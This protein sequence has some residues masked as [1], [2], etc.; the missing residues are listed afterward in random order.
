MA[1][2]VDYQKYIQDRNTC[3]KLIK[4]ARRD[5]ERNIASGCKQNPKSFWRYVQ[6]MTKM[7]TGIGVLIDG[8]G[9]K[10]GNE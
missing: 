9:E 8:N 2:G 1:S 5:Y 6:E 4:R 7:K 3:T 10:A